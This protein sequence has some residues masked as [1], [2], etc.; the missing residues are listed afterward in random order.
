MDPT[1]LYDLRELAKELHDRI[2]PEDQ[3]PDR[4]LF[5]TDNQRNE[6]KRL[7]ELKMENSSVYLTGCIYHAMRSKTLDLE[8]Q[9]NILVY[10]PHEVAAVLFLQSLE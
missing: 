9:M 5:E 7:S 10:L 4:R 2:G 6:I 3:Y 1:R 8:K